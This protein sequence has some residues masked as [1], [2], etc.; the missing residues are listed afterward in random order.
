MFRVQDRR[1][2]AVETIYGVHKSGPANEQT[3]FLIFNGHWQWV[4]ARSYLP[5]PERPKRQRQSE[6]VGL[7]VA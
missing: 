3:K 6:A 7:V 1:T 4:W 5:L 2:G